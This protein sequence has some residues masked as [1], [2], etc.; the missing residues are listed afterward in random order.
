MVG[1]G[2]AVL[3]TTIGFV[4][5]SIDQRWVSLVGFAIVAAG[6]TTGVIAIFYGWLKEG[7]RAI[8]GSWQGMG[9]LRDCIM[10]FLKRSK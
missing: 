9:S 3:G 5:F 10:R 8:G 4:G 2:L 7:R 1:F 6:V